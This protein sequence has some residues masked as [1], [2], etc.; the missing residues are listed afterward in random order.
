V[1]SLLAGHGTQASWS[2]A[3]RHFFVIFLRLLA[4]AISF[5]RPSA[6]YLY[7]FR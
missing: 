1:L 7:R 5:A 4:R 2:G 6:R 3:G